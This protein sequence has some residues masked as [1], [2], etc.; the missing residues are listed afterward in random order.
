MK[1]FNRVTLALWCAL[2]FAAS[3]RAQT[4][5]SLTGLVTD[6][7][8][9][10]IPDATIT[11]T[12]TGTNQVREVKSDAAGRYFFPQ[13]IPG[14][15]RLLAKKEGFSD[16]SIQGIRLLVN[17]PATVNVAFEKVGQ[18]ATTVEVSAE[19]VQV[20]T[21]DATLGNSFGTKPILQ[22]PFE[23][24]N[25]AKILSLQAGVSW[26][27][28]SDTVN[29]GVSTAIDRGGVV[30]GGR[31]DQS[32][33]TLDGID[34][35]DQQTRA[36]FTS[37]L[38]V[39]LDSVQEFRVTTTNANADASRGSGAQITL[40]TKSGT[41]DLHGSAYWFVRN[42]EFN[43]NTFFNNLTGLRTPK[44]NRNIAGASLGGPLKKNRLFLFGNVE[45]RRDLFEQ[46]ILRTVP[47]ATIRQGIAS[48]VS[49]AGNVVQVSPAELASR[50]NYAPGV[51]QA[52][53]EVF[54]SY[55]LP[56]DPTAG[57][58]INTSGF[59]F[60]APIR[61][62]FYTYIARLDYVLNDKHNFFVRGQ[63]QD[64]VENG[65]PQFPGR[66]PNF[67]SLTNSKGI[68][69]GWNA[70]LRP[71]IF[72]TTR[73]GLT[74]QSLE[75]A[76]IGTY[77]IVSW[78]PLSDPVGLTR[79]FRRI[80][81]THHLTQ[82]FTWTRGAHTFQFG[83]SYRHF[84]NDRLSWDNSFFTA[85]SNSSWLT[86]SGNILSA[87]FTTGDP[88]VAI[89]PGGRTQFNDAVAMVFGLVTQVN[90]RYNYLPR[91]G[92][93]V[94]LGRGEPNPRA[95]LGTESEVYF[96]DTWKLT[97]S[98]T[99]TAGLRYMYWPAIYEKR[100]VQ[101]SPTIPL[102]D[103]FDRR[104]A[105]ANA[106]L[107][108]QTGL[109][110]IE[111]TLANMPGGR[112]LYSNL[113]NWSPR[114]ALAWSP[115]SDNALARFLFGGP[116]KS[117][118][119][120][121]WGMYYDVF[122][123]GLIR[124]YDA[125]A[126]GLSTN[127]PNSSGRLTLADAPRFTGTF[128]IPQQLITPPPPAGFPIRQPNSFQI[129]NSLD[130]RLRAPYVMRWNVSWQ[131]EMKGGWLLSMAYVASE[132]RRTLTSEDLATPVNLRDP[133]SG[134]TWYEAAGLL[135]SR[136]AINERREVLRPL[137]NAELLRVAP[138]P[139]FENMF[140]GLAGGGLTATQAA[141]RLMEDAHPDAT[142]WLEL[143][144]RFGDPAFSRLGPF[145]FYSP[146]FSYL[147]AIRSVGA[148]SYHSAQLGI[149]K[150]FRNGDQIDF[151]WTWSHSIDMGSV[152]EN[153][154]STSDGLRG[155]IISPYRRHLMRASSDFDQ[156]HNL[157]ANYVYN[158]PLGRGRRFFGSIGKLSNLL[159][160]GWQIAGL[161]RQTTGLPTSVGH[162]RTW[163]TNYNITGWAT[164]IAPA[165]DGTNKNAPAPV[166]N[167]ANPQA[168]ARLSGPN[169]FQNPRAALDAFGFTLPG[170]I[171]NRNN[172]RGDGVFN[173]DASLAKNIFMP[174][175]EK[176]TL[177][178]RWEVFNVTNTVRFD[179]ANI[180][181]SLGNRTNF[182]R[183]QGT[184]QPSR[185]MQ[186]SVRY[187]F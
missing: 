101:T 109:P 10:A 67:R 119:R 53:L 181:L 120:A 91:N 30:N 141:L 147:R 111:F 148:S 4:L 60:N 138:I 29:G 47:T 114:I 173:L 34:V 116:G 151:N 11:I 56:N 22:L 170:D 117:V 158:L 127:I 20:N 87:P 134:Q 27:G 179:P 64:D 70:T 80:S 85:S 177:Q 123:A 74:R 43:A 16:V 28:D 69:I 185:V 83:G 174:Y 49:R 182:G 3:L 97:R 14:E 93:V 41:N 130:D 2:V 171:G 168:E 33:I 24:R 166:A 113:H 82:D 125:S 9:A 144:D 115:Q 104:V 133:A 187:D 153:N 18:V 61:N 132:G 110:P 19:A 159:V 55:P 45:G 100:G 162:N 26:V 1:V 42:R 39:T 5:T 6:P 65:P 175:N 112:P 79:S 98:L 183:Y 44:L 150:Q 124:A 21:T 186:L 86:A 142:Y 167:P 84:T 51:N 118:L 52:A 94:P 96:Q 46:S 13:V 156:R 128:N 129:T 136:M 25:V 76:G 163:P 88:S 164:Q 58:G 154:Q 7:T 105:N 78:R 178:F 75:D 57:D 68:A 169:I 50:L 37:V 92:Q 165:A 172:I 40:V 149:R 90:S 38:R 122:G 31:S 77:E 108:A 152:T 126:L 102:S 23:G 72:S 140:P 59:R 54:R 32:N 63:L 107:G 160:G 62:D 48:Y 121:G 89:N 73:Y 15:Y 180:N 12:N 137:T 161:F 35:N 81:P 17:T 157:N 131:R 146:Q 66:P 143:T 155:V 145:A 99:M 95:F 106:G 139:F 8:G 103:W 135:I 184:L 71:T 176:H 36:A